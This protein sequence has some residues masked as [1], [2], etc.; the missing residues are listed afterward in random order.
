M[1]RDLNCRRWRPGAAVLVLCLAPL[2]ACGGDSGPE[3]A[4]LVE[5]SLLRASDLPQGQEWEVTDDE[6][7]AGLERLE[8]DLDACERR[9]D[10]TVESSEAEQESDTFASGLD[11]VSSTGWVVRDAATREAFFD[12]LD[13]QFVCLGRALARYLRAVA[14]DGVIIE[15]G[16][17]Y[18]LDVETAADRTAGRAIQVGVTYPGENLARVSWFVDAVAVEDGD[19]LAGYFFFHEGGITLEEET[20]AVSRALVRVDEEHEG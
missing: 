4:D 5:A 2:A 16:S 15:V 11:S 3:A 18:A 8:D 13:D 19:L 20:E 14:G 1:R 12:S 9:H 17:P 7:D 10:P 6:T